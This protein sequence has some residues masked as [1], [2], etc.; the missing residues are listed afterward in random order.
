M[1]EPALVAVTD[2]LATTPGVMFCVKAVDGRY[3]MANLAFAE[4]AGVDGPGD[5]VGRTA[6]DLFPLEL[7]KRYEAQDAEVLTTGRMLTNELELITR[8]DGSPGWFLTSKSRWL[9][10]NGDPGGLVSVSVDLR[11]PDDAA[12]PH[13]RLAD[14][15]DLAR[16]H[17]ADKVTVGQMADA[18]AMSV[19]Q[20]ERS[21]RRV[22][23]LSPKQLIMRFRVEEALRLLETTDR[24]LSE[25]APRCGYYD[26]SA[27]TRHFRRV[28]G[29]G[30]AGW[31]DHR[32]VP[33]EKNQSPT[34][35]P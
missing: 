3:L 4:R 10:R 17:Y 31:R 24:P 16:R 26:Q 5:V 9:D 35:E 18:A 27:L 22:L 14:A 29:F 2:V 8:T 33:D 21:F 12:A 13:E 1:L 11:A 19:P 7:A 32:A 23:G 6:A 30:P 34:M 20:L 15:V 28:V 25:I